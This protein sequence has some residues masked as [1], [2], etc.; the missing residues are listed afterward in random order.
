MK[1]LVVI[2]HP[3]PN[4]FNHALAARIVTAWEQLGAKVV[5]RDLAVETF[6]PRL[7]PE[8]ARGA[9][10]TDPLVR[11]HIADLASADL[12]A[13]V[14]PVM[15]GMPP[16][17]L[18]GWIDRVF[19]LNVAYGF[20][21]GTAEGTDPIGLLPLRAALILNTSN[22]SPETEAARFGDPLDR[23]WRDCILGY[24]STAQVTRRTFAPLVPSTDAA[25]AA[26][27]DQAAIL[28]QATISKA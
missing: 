27:L 3:A 10:T 25:R 22:T 20:P 16:A 11:R 13:V 2:G 23:I 17:I 15:W 7:T 6:D 26:W 9:P 8:E 19:A 28:A 5:V 14:H 12:L 21:Q 24:C 4:S 1:A 18:K